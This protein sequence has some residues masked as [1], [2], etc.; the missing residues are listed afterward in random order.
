M[1]KPIQVERKAL[2]ALSDEEI[3]A[4]LALWTKVWPKY[5]EAT[6]ETFR[7]KCQAQLTGGSTWCEVLYV[8][9][10]PHPKAAA[11]VFERTIAAGTREIPILALAAVCTDPDGRGHGTGHAIV[12][13]AFG[14]VARGQYAWALFQTSRQVRP[15]YERLGATVVENHIFDST[16]ADPTEPA[17]RDEVVMRYPAR[18]RGWPEGPLDLRGPGY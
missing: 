5:G 9:G 12:R 15:F 14:Y 8:P 17:F 1:N 4:L 13:A 18:N 16:A 10:T 3:N 6:P 2:L 7:A 11:R